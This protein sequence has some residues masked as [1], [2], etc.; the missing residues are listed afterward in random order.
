M[1]PDTSIFTRPLTKED[2]YYFIDTYPHST[3]VNSPLRK[4]SR[5]T[6]EFFA[7]SYFKDSVKLAIFARDNGYSYEY[8]N[9]SPSFREGLLFKAGYQSRYIERVVDGALE[10]GRIETYP[11]TRRSALL[12]WGYAA[13]QLERQLPNIVLDAKRNNRRILGIS[14]GSN[15]PYDFEPAQSL[16][17]EG[18]FSDY[19]NLYVPAGYENDALYIFTPDLMAQMIDLGAECDAEIVGDK[20]IFYLP[21]SRINN[22]T[23]DLIYNLRDKLAEKTNTKATRYRDELAGGDLPIDQIS[24]RGSRLKSRRSYVLALELIGVLLCVLLFVYVSK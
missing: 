12:Q 6:Y 7:D 17:L 10:Y 14:S 3:K 5:S 4:L 21:S 24:S 9:I 11:A 15:L 23:I 22:I 8:M 13:F 19:F 18:N 16:K 20:L 2:K 1:R